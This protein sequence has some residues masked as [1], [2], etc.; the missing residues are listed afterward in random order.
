MPESN[1]VPIANGEP[2]LA[3][4]SVTPEIAERWLGKNTRNRNVRQAIVAGYARDMAAGNWYL[5]GEPIIFADDGT[6]LDGQHRL[7]AVIRANVTVQV[8][9]V[10]GVAADAMATIDTGGGRKFAD[11]LAID[12]LPNS[13]TLAALVR[14]A[15]MWDAGQRTNAGRLKPTRLEMLDYLDRNPQIRHS[16]DVAK[17]LQSRSLLPA[18]VI[19]LA[20]WLFSRTDADDATW[21]ISRVVD[22]DVPTDHPARVLHRRIV[23]MRLAGG[24]VN[25]TEALAL[26][27]RAW[28]AHRANQR[29]QKF[30]MP[31][32][33]LSNE[34]FPEPR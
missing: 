14:R 31:K 34:N 28:N 30:Q 12:G 22:E 16:A 17:T 1:V 21:F 27:I 15:H 13:S 11:V 25:E 8:L 9:V 20:H 26:T 32:G 5:N 29:P 2:R 19:G 24:R 18:S 7:H 23:A 3:V 10:R 6:L 33:G 4:V